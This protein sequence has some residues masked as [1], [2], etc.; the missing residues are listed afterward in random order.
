MTDSGKN[1]GGV[2]AYTNTFQLQVTQVQYPP[3]FIGITDVTLWEN[4]SSNLT[5]AF[6][7]YDPLTTNF[8]VSCVSSNT[9]LATVSAAT[10]GT[11][12]T[13]TSRLWPAPAAAPPSRSRRVTAR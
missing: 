8:T 5:L 7:L 9:K 13:I 6:S 4:T 3:A 2:N 11:A 10:V 12:G 1:N